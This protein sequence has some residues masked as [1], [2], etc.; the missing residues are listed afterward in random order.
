MRWLASLCK[1]EPLQSVNWDT[2]MGSKLNQDLTVIEPF[3]DTGV[4]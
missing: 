2:G 3:F 4:P 1:G